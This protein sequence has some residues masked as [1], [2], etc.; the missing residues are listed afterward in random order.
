MMDHTAIA[1]YDYSV[2]GS[3]EERKRSLVVEVLNVNPSPKAL[4]DAAPGCEPFGRFEGS[5]AFCWRST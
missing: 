4:P 2:R 1:A 5:S 3:K